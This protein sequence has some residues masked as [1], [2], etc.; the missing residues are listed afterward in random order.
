MSKKRN[1]KHK[2]PEQKARC[3]ICGG[4]IR[5]PV[6]VEDRRSYAHKLGSAPAQLEPYRLAPGEA[7]DCAVRAGIWDREGNLMPRYL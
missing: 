6:G 3:E 7:F 2:G 5:Q 4:L 1:G